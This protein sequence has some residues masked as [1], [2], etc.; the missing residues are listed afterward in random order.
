MEDLKQ[1]QQ[2]ALK[3]YAKGQTKSEVIS[4]LK[5][6]GYDDQMA[7][8]LATNF[9]QNHNG[10]K[11][12]ERKR[13]RKAIGTDQLIG[14]FLLGIGLALTLASYLF[15]GNVFFVFWGLMLGGLFF[16]GRSFVKQSELGDVE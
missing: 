16:L 10:L 6:T 1:L 13:L 3:M 8:R 7:E 11:M 5:E 4:M 15:L 2:L 14:S 9:E 12:E